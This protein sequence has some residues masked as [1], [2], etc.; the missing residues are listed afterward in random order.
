MSKSGVKFAVILVALI[1]SVILIVTIVSS[2]VSIFQLD[3]DIADKEALIRAKQD[4]NAS[5]QDMIDSNDLSEYAASIA[6]EKL[7]FGTRTEKMYI[8]ITGK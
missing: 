5:L 8:N 6:R 3:S 7:G 1:I 4:E 2:R